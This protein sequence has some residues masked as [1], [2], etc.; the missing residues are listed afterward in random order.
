MN[1]DDS[2]HPLSEDAKRVLEKMQAGFA[3]VGSVNDYGRDLQLESEGGN[4]RE[5]VKVSIAKELLDSGRIRAT[6]K[7]DG[8]TEYRQL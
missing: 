5:N 8:H 1:S 4:S 2:A 3:L 6:A 7:R